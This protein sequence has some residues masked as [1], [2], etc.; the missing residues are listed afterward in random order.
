MSLLIEYYTEALL[1]L[2]HGSHDMIETENESLRERVADLEKKVL[3][4]GD[5]I[6]CLRSTLADVLRRLNQFESRGGPI[7]ENRIPVRNGSVVHRVLLQNNHVQSSPQYKDSPSSMKK[8]QG[9]VSDLASRDPLRRAASYASS[10]PQRRV[11]HYQS[12][13][14]LHSDS[15]SSNSVSPV[16]TSPSPTHT[17]TP[18]PPQRATP[19]GTGRTT[20][21]QKYSAPQRPTSVGNLSLAKRWSSTGDFHNVGITSPQS[22]M[23]TASRLA[24]KSL[25]NL[26]MR[27]QQHHPSLKHGQAHQFGSTRAPI[28]GWGWVTVNN[29]V[30]FPPTSDGADTLLSGD[31]SPVTRGY[32]Q[33]MW[34]TRD[35]SFNEEEGSVRI[36]LR[37]R[38]IVLY[39]PSELAESYDLNKV[40]TPPQ[41]RLKLDYGYRGRDGRSNLYLLPTGE[42]VYFVAAAVVLYNV[43]EQSQRHYL[44]HTDDVKW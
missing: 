25:F 22:A 19:I 30:D 28:R 32:V 38:P 18:P 34:R 23:A 13:G 41:T 29:D 3:E 26:Y 2:L 27:P 11:V 6:V 16:P 1:N 39:A 24:T 36:F 15:P 9:S 20:P 43:E 37:G 35:A 10:L 8:Y 21:T 17:P 7:P 4:Q 14:S 40:T 42:M 5:E 44:G 12:T 31:W 33:L